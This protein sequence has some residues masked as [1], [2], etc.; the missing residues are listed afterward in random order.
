MINIKEEFV[1]CE[2]WERAIAD[3]G[4]AAIQL[5]LAIKGYAARHPMDGFIGFEAL[6]T[7]KGRPVQPRQMKR[8]L[9]ALVNCGEPQEDGSKGAGLLDV[10][11]H[12]YR[13]HDYLDHNASR[14]EEEERRESAK[15]A[16]RLQRARAL[17]R[18]LG[19]DV[20]G[21][22]DEQVLAIKRPRG[23]PPKVSG[24]FVLNC[25]E[26]EFEDNS[27][28]V[29]SR[30]PE[31]ARVRAP[32]RPHPNPTQPNPEEEEDPPSLQPIPREL[33]GDARKRPDVQRVFELWKLVFGFSKAQFRKTGYCCATADTI[34]A[35]VDT[36]GETE[37]VRVLEYA[38]RDT[39]VNGTDDEGRK[40]DS[41]NYLLGTA[42]VFA[43]LQRGA[44]DDEKRLLA[45]AKSGNHG[46]RAKAEAEAGTLDV[47]KF[48]RFLATKKAKA[49]G[50]GWQPSKA[51]GTGG[52]P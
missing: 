41:V 4:P 9:D 2:K 19:I 10:E 40:H 18:K 17:A 34:A 29:P 28:D 39:M 25:P 42:D 5:W 30:G 11:D 6:K 15:V 16:K 14:E 1:G 38:P 7:L 51:I 43:R 47:A 36:H 35:A 23:R 32:A 24:E 44:D 12:G 52:G 13:L 22:S 48:R 37:V 3:G 27:K 50:V 45:L 46:D 21:W 31:P 8:A 26:D 20:T 33:G 49:G